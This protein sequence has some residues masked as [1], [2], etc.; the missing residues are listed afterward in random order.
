MRSGRVDCFLFQRCPLRCYCW[1]CGC[2]VLLSSP[3]LPKYFY[4]YTSSFQSHDG[5]T[6]CLFTR[7][8]SSFCCFP[9]HLS[10]LCRHLLYL[11]SSSWGMLL[12]RLCIFP[13]ELSSGR[14]LF[15]TAFP[16]DDFEGAFVFSTA[17]PYKILRTLS[18][19]PQLLCS[20]RRF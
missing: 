5:F 10:L 7:R 12:P 2:V 16:Y 20:F 1:R 4:A 9:V 17:S 3:S 19:P 6:H 11:L 8:I 14:F 15:S 18:F 13:L